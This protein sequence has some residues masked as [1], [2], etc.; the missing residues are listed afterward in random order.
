M[1]KDIIRSG[2][3]MNFLLTVLIFSILGGVISALGGWLQHRDNP[4][5]DTSVYT[6]LFALGAML[7]AGALF[8]YSAL[9]DSTP[10]TLTQE[11]YTG[12][13]DF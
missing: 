3:R 5:V 1:F 12:N 9:A 7:V 11:I 4:E 13:P 6:K 10:S 8:G 2:G